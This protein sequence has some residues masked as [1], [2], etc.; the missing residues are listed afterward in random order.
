MWVKANQTH[1]VN[2]YDNTSGSKD[3]LAV[4]EDLLTV[5]V[6]PIMHDV[7]HQHSICTVHCFRQWLE[8]VG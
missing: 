5:C 1:H 4:L 3:C 8:K 7:L 2:A 6:T